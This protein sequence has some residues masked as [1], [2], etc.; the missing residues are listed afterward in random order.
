M[1]RCGQADIR[2]AAA[3]LE[4]LEAVIRQRF[5]RYTRDPAVNADVA[6]I[7]AAAREYRDA[8]EPW[9]PE[10]VHLDGSARLMRTACR[11]RWASYRLDLCVTA[12]ADRV[13]CGSCLRSVLYR[14]MTGGVARS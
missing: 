2:P 11:A 5:A 10:V 9:T 6:A 1:D 3:A 14:E 4:A 8:A 13:T 12:R 7:L